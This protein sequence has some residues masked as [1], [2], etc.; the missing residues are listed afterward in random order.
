M[1][2]ALE[3]VYALEKKFAAWTT[4]FMG[5]V[6]F[7]DVIH[8]VA[9]R[10]RGL[11]VR[12]FGDESA[13][14]ANPLGTAV[15]LAVALGVTYAALVVRGEAKGKRTLGKAAIVVAVG[16][17]AVRLFLVVLPNGLVWSQTLGLVLMLWIGLVGASMATRDHRHLA[18]DLGSKLWPKRALPFVQAAGNVVTALFCFVLAALSV[19]SLR[20]HFG[21]WSD[22]DGAGGTFVALPIPKWIAYTVVPFGFSLMGLRFLLL[23]MAGAKGEVEEDDPMHMLGLDEDMKVAAEHDHAGVT[24]DKGGA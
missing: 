7:L 19:V 17:G 18:L 11:L 3:R 14:W 9:S 6:V 24:A 10:E 8:R 23:A 16:Y 13:S 21:D 5:F 22:T 12:M 15:G 2:G 1:K 4:A 20:D